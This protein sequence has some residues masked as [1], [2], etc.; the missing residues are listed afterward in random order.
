M[1]TDTV[2]EQRAYSLA[3][4]LEYGQRRYEQ[5]RATG[6]QQERALWEMASERQTMERETGVELRWCQHCGEGVTVP[7]EC[8]GDMSLCPIGNTVQFLKPSCTSECPSGNS[9]RLALQCVLDAI[10]AKIVPGDIGGSGFDPT[11]QRNGLIIAANAVQ[12]MMDCLSPENHDKTVNEEVDRLRELAATCYAGLGAECDL[13]AN[14]L[15]VLTAAANGEPFS[16]DGLL[17]FQKSCP[18]DCKCLMQ[19]GDTAAHEADLLAKDALRF[20]W[21][22]EDHDD[23]DER[24]KCREILSRMWC[25]SHS[26]ASQAIDAAIA[27]FHPTGW[28]AGP[29]V[30]GQ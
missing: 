4:V 21:L 15:D 5:G 19:C 26:K 17:P 29:V 2:M 1:A 9:V 10:N 14:W 27:E 23:D 11:A 25:M 12:Q 24:D 16:L 28:G 13:P 18:A 7:G 6:A 8:R 20:R 3:E 22:T 30:A